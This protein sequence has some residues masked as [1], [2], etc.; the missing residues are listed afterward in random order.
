[1]AEIALDLEGV[2]AD[3]HSATF[4]ESDTLHAGLNDEWG[5]PD[6]LYEEFLTVSQ[7]LW[8]NSHQKIPLE[9]P[10]VAFLVDRLRE[11]HEVHLVTNRHGA[12]EQIQKWLDEN[13]I[14]VDGFESNPAG[15]VKGKLGYD[16]Y[17]DDNP[18]MIDEDN[19]DHLYLIAHPYNDLEV[20][21]NTSRVDGLAEVVD[22]VTSLSPY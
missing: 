8:E 18:G 9:E 22:S 2:C 10:N 4:E 3:T 15:T 16:I 20:D 6:G 17:I 1:M 13:D 5:F 21:G 12:D 7:N 19:G 11:E 14:E